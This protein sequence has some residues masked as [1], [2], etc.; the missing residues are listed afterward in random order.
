[1]V[2]ALQ[3]DGAAEPR[4]ILAEFRRLLRGGACR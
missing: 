4:A 3:P 2:F 1:L